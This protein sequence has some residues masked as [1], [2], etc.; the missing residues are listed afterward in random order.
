MWKRYVGLLSLA[1][2]ICLT[3]LLS[4]LHPPVVSADHSRGCAPGQRSATAFGTYWGRPPVGGLVVR[5]IWYLPSEG[6]KQL[7]RFFPAPTRWPYTA[8]FYTTARVDGPGEYI[9]TV[10]VLTAHSHSA[11]LRC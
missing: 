2:L 8:S 11:V 9:Q 3:V 10:L 1:V 4:D 5:F 7:D 6:F